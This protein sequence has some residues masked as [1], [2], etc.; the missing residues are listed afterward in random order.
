MS[1]VHYK[2]II[3]CGQPV[4][5]YSTTIGESAEAKTKD[6]RNPGS[7]GGVRWMRADYQD[8]KT[9]VPMPTLNALLDPAAK[10]Q[11]RTTR[12]G[13]GSLGIAGS[14]QVRGR[15]RKVVQFS[16]GGSLRKKHQRLHAA[17]VA[18]NNS[19]PEPE[20]IYINEGP[21][22]SPARKDETKNPLG[23]GVAAS[24]GC[25]L[26]QGELPALELKD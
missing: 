24:T 7:T 9:S 4:L 16:E 10:G 26:P 12:P 3:V 22:L 13:N 18:R 19:I 23:F 1:E 20:R 5:M 11:K 8:I 2:T 15:K 14:L 21:W 25:L 6:K 17:V